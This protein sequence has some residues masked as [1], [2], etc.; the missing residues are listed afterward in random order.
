MVSYFDI[1]NITL[2]MQVCCPF[3][4][5]HIVD[6][7]KLLRHIQK[8]KS[9]NRPNFL[10]C[11]FNQVH[12]VHFDQFERHKKGNSSLKQTVQIATYTPP[13][14][15]SQEKHQKRLIARRKK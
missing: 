2:A 10:P 12:W 1:N 15:S 6:S 13:F 5:S 8:C 4:I 9:S 11:P 14:F 3:D 7:T